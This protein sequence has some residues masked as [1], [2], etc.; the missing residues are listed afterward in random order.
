MTSSHHI[1]LGGVNF[2]SISNITQMEI[3]LEHTF[4]YAAYNTRWYND[5]K[6]VK[7]NEEINTKQG[8]VPHSA[9]N[10]LT[11]GISLAHLL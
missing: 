4:M 5:V 3:Y 7:K 10:F 6:F 2:Y 1:N 8:I 11:I 9:N